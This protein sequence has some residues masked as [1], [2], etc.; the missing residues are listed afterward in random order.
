MIKRECFRIVIWVFLGL[1]VLTSLTAL[2]GMYRL[3]WQREQKLYIGKDV[4]QQ[5]IAVFKRA[6]LPAEILGT[7]DTINQN[8]PLDIRY[9]ALGNQ[10]I[11]SYLSYL[12]IPRVPS[13][14]S[15]F[16]VY[17]EDGVLK[18]QGPKDSY[19]STFRHNK[20]PQYKGF[21]F[22]VILVSGIAILIRKLFG[23]VSLSLSESFGLSFLLL[24]ALVLLSIKL[25]ESANTGFRVASGI[26]IIGWGYTILSCIKRRH[27]LKIDTLRKNCFSFFSSSTG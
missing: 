10:N 4:T 24:M 1:W 20:T 6:G 5:R 14:M 2:T 9:E 19:G 25:F 27:Y 11:M 26:G 3:W 23:S 22:S 7:I 18:Y 17:F 12:L 16:K 13:K 15:D 21:L 8:W